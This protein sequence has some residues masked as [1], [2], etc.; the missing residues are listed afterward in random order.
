M[1]DST[2]Y[3]TIKIEG[4]DMKSQVQ[5]IDVEDHDRAIDRAQVVFD[6]ADDVSAITREQRKVQINLGWSDQN[7]LIFEGVV[8][9]VKTEASGNGQSRVT[10]TAYDL[11]YKMKQ[12]QTK[13]RYFISGRLSDALKA[14]LADYPGIGEGRI[15]PD[16]D[17]VFT[18]DKPWGKA[19]G[20]SD[21]DFIQD[22]A[23]VWKARTFVEV[24]N[25]KSQFYFVSEQSLNKGDPMGVLHYCP[26]GVGPLL[27]FEY[28]RIG[29]G[30]SPLS[31]ATV[32]DPTTGEPVN[33][34]L[35]PP[36][37]DPPLVV[38]PTA[39]ATFVQAAGVMAGSAGRTK[40]ARPQ[41]VVKGLPSDPLRMQQ[42][43]QQ[44]PTR[45]LGYSG[46]GTC[47]GTIMLRAKG[48]V[49]IK[50]LPPWAEG[51]WYVH[52]VNHI[53]RRLVV[54]DKND[55]PVDRSTYE[56]KFFVTR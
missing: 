56:S 30:A 43:I 33:Q 51:D 28:K 11:S 41:T 48:K 49:T 32:I 37:D 7:A 15:K 44:D 36:A 10:V 26:G 54:S 1:A 6:S 13:D 38:D 9:G 50:G 39:D 14:I 35:P 42:H 16:P 46:R 47:R 31:T 29:S 40:D 25:N 2:P 23:V 45:I 53:Y 18:P 27:E 55:K 21:W 24:N 8:M 5:S 20:K 34:P 12:N 4:V 17:P 52:R 3:A 22:A 19:S